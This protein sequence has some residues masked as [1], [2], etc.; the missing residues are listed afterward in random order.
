MKKINVE[1]LDRELKTAGIPI[2][3]VSSNGRIDFEDGATE[4]Q[5]KLAYSI[6]EKH[7]PKEYMEKRLK[8]YPPLSEFV[9][10]FYW[11]QKGNDSFMEIYI[12]KCTQVKAKYP[13]S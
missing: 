4:A 2:H 13:K 7:D 12:E 3:G 5:I 8:E 1:L 11:A 10:A 6:L 9:D